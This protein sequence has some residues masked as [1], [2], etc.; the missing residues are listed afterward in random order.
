MEKM[1]AGRKVILILFILNVLFIWFN[2][3]LDTQHTFYFSDKIT[4]KVVES[5]SQI[6]SS[7]DSS[8]LKEEASALKNSETAA[9]KANTRIKISVYVRKT[10]HFI[11]FASLGV[12]TSLLLVYKRISL[13]KLRDILFIGIMIA[14][15]DETIQ[16]FSHRTSSVSDVW[17]DAAGFMIGTAAVLF[18]KYLQLKKRK[19]KQFI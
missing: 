5:S 8:Q 7:A 9:Y 1:T 6:G 10:A 3:A 11:E 16:I 12:L 2:S 4:D 13:S 17:I 14:L 15:L 19:K 18:I